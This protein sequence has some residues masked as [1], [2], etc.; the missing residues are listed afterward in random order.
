MIIENSTEGSISSKH[1]ESILALTVGFNPQSPFMWL[2]IRIEPPI[3]VP[4]PTRDPCRAS[5]QASPPLEPPGV[6]SG[7]R[8]FVVKPQR[9]FSVS[10]HS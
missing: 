1:E 9:G 3:S 7:L 8:G 4:H 10:H 5:K 2:G 6:N